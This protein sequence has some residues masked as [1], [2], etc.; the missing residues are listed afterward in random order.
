LTV[1]TA[2]DSPPLLSLVSAEQ[3]LRA[4]ILTTDEIWLAALRAA[5]RSP[6]TIAS[7]RHAIGCLQQWRGTTELDD[8]TRSEAYRFVQWLGDNYKPG[9]VAIRVRSL[10]AYYGWLVKEELIDRSPFKGITISVPAEAKLTPSEDEIDAMLAKAKGHR[11]DHALLLLLV[12]SG[13][14]KGEVA[15]LTVKDVDLASGMVTFRVSKTVARTVPLTI[16]ASSL[17]ASGCGN[18]ATAAGRCGVSPIRT[19]WCGRCS[20]ATPSSPRTHYAE[21]PP[22]APCGWGSAS[23][24]SSASSGGA[25]GRANSRPTSGHAATS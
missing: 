16:V 21:Q 11:R 14:R 17:S 7:Y 12:D 6:A 13:A 9:G 3:S 15:A 18:G 4:A 5:G 2:T 1:Q 23:R 10:R 8:V 19:R 22:F 24:R 20:I 25:V